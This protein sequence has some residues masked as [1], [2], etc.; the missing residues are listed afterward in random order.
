MKELF[1]MRLIQPKQKIVSLILKQLKQFTKLRNWRNWF[2]GLRETTA[3]LST[4]LNILRN[5]PLGGLAVINSSSNSTVPP[6]L[7]EL[8]EQKQKQTQSLFKDRQRAR[9]GAEVVRDILMGGNKD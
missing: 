3:L 1:K 5:S 8:I 2:L 4:L 9:E 6:T 7:V